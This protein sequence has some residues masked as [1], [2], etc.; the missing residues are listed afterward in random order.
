M[1]LESYIKKHYGPCITIVA[2]RSFL[3]AYF[4]LTLGDNVLFQLNQSL[5]P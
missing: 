1:S 4:S 3:Q 5:I 2:V